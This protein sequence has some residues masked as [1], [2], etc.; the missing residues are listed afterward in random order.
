[1]PTAPTTDQLCAL[2]EMVERSLADDFD[3]PHAF[4]RVS[5][6]D[7]SDDPNEVEFGIKYLDAGEHPV[8]VLL[9]FVAPE[10]WTVFGTVTFGWAAPLDGLRPSKHPKRS[11]VRAVQLIARDG[12]EAA[13]MRAIDGDQ[14]PLSSG[15]GPIAEGNVPDCIRRSLNLP[16]AAPDTPT[17]HLRAVRWLTALAAK[18]H[19]SF[20]G[21][22][23][24]TDEA[25]ALLG[26]IPDRSWAEERWAAV[27]GDGCDEITATEAAWMDDGM[28]SRWVMV[29]AAPAHTLAPDA[30]AACSPAAWRRV[31]AELESWGVALRR[32]RVLG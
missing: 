28:F 11:R 27:T 5:E 25:M 20:N 26:D 19:P 6:V 12:T 29:S 14:V 10:E 15:R 17:S 18:G 22:R 8:D 30:Q 9:G 7:D 23:L 24:L 4:V 16:T 3:G 13:V 21:V 2:A 1:M 32:P 31:R